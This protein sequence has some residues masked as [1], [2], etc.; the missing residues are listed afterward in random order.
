MWIDIISCCTC[1]IAATYRLE[2]LQHSRCH[3]HRFRGNVAEHAIPG[4]VLHEL[5]ADGIHI[6]E[7]PLVARD[8][9]FAVVPEILAN[10]V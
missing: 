3:Q 2:D 5:F 8:E 1:I 9:A 10:L 6:S 7:V 4:E